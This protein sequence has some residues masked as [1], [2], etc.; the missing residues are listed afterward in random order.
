MTTFDLG[1]LYSHVS[2]KLFDLKLFGVTDFVDTAFYRYVFLT[3]SPCFIFICSALIVSIRAMLSVAVS[4][5]R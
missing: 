4:S 2:M 1:P 3:N 5:I